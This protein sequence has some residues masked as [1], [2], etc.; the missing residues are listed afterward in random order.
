MDGAVEGACARK[1][2]D[3]AA[4]QFP[5]TI[6]A[7]AAGRSRGRRTPPILD[8]LAPAMQEESDLSAKSPFLR[9][10]GASNEAEKHLPLI[11]VRGSSKESR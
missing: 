5:P 2:G 8:I 10:S 6:D 1:R 9:G 3:Q 7:L 4:A 11:V